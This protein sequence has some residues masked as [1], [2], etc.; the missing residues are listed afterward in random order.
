MRQKRMVPVKE[1]NYGGIG[2]QGTGDV[3]RPKRGLPDAGGDVV[4]VSRE[5]I[6][7]RNG[8]EML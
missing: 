7:F 6:A 1:L 5:R 3:R 8:A 4:G 2:A